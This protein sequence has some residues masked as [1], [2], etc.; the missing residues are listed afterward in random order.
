MI[1]DQCG[2]PR[3]SLTGDG[4]LVTFGACRSDMWVA[5]EDY[6]ICADCW[7]DVV[8]KCV[9]GGVCVRGAS[10]CARVCDCEPGALGVPAEL[11]VGG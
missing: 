6:L 10:A 8:K 9:R 3:D 7:V 2:G 1:S 11:D 5:V 4:I